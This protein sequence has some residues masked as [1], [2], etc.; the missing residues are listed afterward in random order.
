MTSVMVRRVR[1][2]PKINTII[3]KLLYRK[4]DLNMPKLDTYGSQPPI[5][6]LRQFQDFGGMYDREKLFWKEF[7]VSE[8]NKIIII[9]GPLLKRRTM[10]EVISRALYTNNNYNVQNS[11]SSP[12]S[13]H[14]G[15]LIYLGNLRYFVL[16]CIWILFRQKNSIY[17]II[18]WHQPKR[19]ARKGYQRLTIINTE[20]APDIATV[21]NYYHHK[22]GKIS[23]KALAYIKQYWLDA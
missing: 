20:M 15:K 2:C 7:Q 10:T 6:L 4:A 17:I 21:H 11:C 13:N 8:N 18:N 9:F 16:H 12:V 14:T 1:N 19:Y 3:I 23:I 5:E 22:Q